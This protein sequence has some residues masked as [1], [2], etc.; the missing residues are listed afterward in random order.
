MATVRRDGSILCIE[1]DVYYAAVQT[2]GY[3]SGVKGE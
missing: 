3:V 1:T 2:E